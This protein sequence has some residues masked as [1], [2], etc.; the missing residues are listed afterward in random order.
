MLVRHVVR[1]SLLEENLALAWPGGS[2]SFPDLTIR[3]DPVLTR[4]PLPRAGRVWW[5][6]VL[7]L[8]LAACGG[9]DGATGAGTQAPA[10]P[11]AAAPTGTP[12]PADA[13]TQAADASA[14]TL[15]SAGEEPRTELR[16]DLSDGQPVAATIRQTQ[17][18]EQIID[19][20]RGPQVSLTSLF[21]L[22]GDVRTDGDLFTMRVS[23]ENGRVADV[24]D[25]DLAEAMSESMST[26]EGMT[27]VNTFDARGR[28]IDSG[29]ENAD[30]YEGNPM[31]SMIEQS[32]LSAPL[33]E[34]PV[35]VGARWSS[36]Q[37]L[38]S[39]VSR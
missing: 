4:R 28:I 20:Q 6:A 14:V 1:S 29:I 21:D 36:T 33:P 15:I 24:T 2:D 10:S 12:A 3:G 13:T 8:I 7:M 16:Y 19:G 31:M 18:L 37:K 9:E 34:E 25:P 17:E 26:L 5:A 30:A 39:Q 32:N 35:G 38:N 11:E 27:I 22:V 23:L